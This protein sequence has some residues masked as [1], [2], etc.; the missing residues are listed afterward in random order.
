MK[1]TETP[2]L[3]T[4]EEAEMMN[5]VVGLLTSY[6]MG[7]APDNAKIGLTHAVFRGMKVPILCVFEVKGDE[8]EV[9]PLAILMVDEIHEALEEVGSKDDA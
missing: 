1:S 6:G 4:E 7:D 3:F 5:N 8:M 2:E 9:Y